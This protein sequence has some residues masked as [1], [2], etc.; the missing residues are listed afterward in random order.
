[1]RGSDGDY[2]V[3][4]S[5]V[6]KERI[7]G[8]DLFV[9]DR[10]GNIVEG[11]RSERASKL[12][13]SDCT[14]LFYNAFRLRHAGACIHTHSPKAVFLTMLMER[15]AA[16]PE[17]THAFREFKISHVEMIKGIYDPVEKR[18]LHFN[19]VLVVPIIDNTNFECELTDSMAQAMTEY[20][21]TN[22]VM[23]RRHGIYVWGETWQRAKTMTECYDYLF[24]LAIDM[25]QAGLPLVNEPAASPKA[26]CPA[27]RR[28]STIRARRPPSRSSRSRP[29]R[30]SRSSPRRT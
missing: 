4:P 10:A 30:A 28:T 12:K 22:C 23:V 3:A 15:A 5:G 29:A 20:P 18:N 17:A 8:D 21:S 16:K 1:M 27:T 6:Q 25:L 24:S 13:Q 9:L 19:E 11:P 14:P 2:Y 26:G 7:V